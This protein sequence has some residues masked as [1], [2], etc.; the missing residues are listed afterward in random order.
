MMQKR[1]K[2]ILGL[3]FAFIMMIGMMN[4]L[5]VPQ[6]LAAQTNGTQLNANTNVPAF[7][8]KFSLNGS[9]I[10][11]LDGAA[12]K[13]V[14]I[15]AVQ[16]GGDKDFM[17]ISI[18]HNKDGSIASVVSS[19]TT[20][21]LQ[22]VTATMGIPQ[23]TEGMYMKA[24][25]ADQSTFSLLTEPAV[26]GS[27]PTVSTLNARS[28]S[29]TLRSAAAPI[30]DFEISLTVNG[31]K[32][33]KLKGT[34]G[35]TIL[36]VAANNGVPKDFVFI[37]S[38]YDSRGRMILTSTANSSATVQTVQNSMTI[39]SNAVNVT[40]KTMIWD[41]NYVPLAPGVAIS[42]D[43]PE[44]ELLTG[45]VSPIVYDD[46]GK[47]KTFLKGYDTIVELRKTGELET[48]FMQTIAAPDTTTGVGT[49]SFENV[50]A[51]EYGLFLSRPGYLLR[52]MDVTVVKSAT[53]T[54][55]PPNNEE[56]FSLIPGDIN[57]NGVVDDADSQIYMHSMEYENKSGS[58]LFKTDFNGDGTLDESELDT[59]I[60]NMGAEFTSYPG[61]LNYT[62][63]AFLQNEPE[64]FSLAKQGAETVT[65][66][67][68]P[69]AYNDIGNGPVF[70]SDYDTLVELRRTDDMGHVY[71]Q[72]IA[73]PDAT[74]G[75]GTFTF[76]DVPTGDYALLLYRPGHMMRT[77]E[78]HIFEDTMYI[79]PSANEEIFTLWP[80]DIDSNG[81]VENFDSNALFNYI[82]A[83]KELMAQWGFDI[84]TFDYNAN[85]VV[86]Q[87]DYDV[88]I[89]HYNTSFANYPDAII[90][91]SI[92][93]VFDYDSGIFIL[94]R[95][96]Q[97]PQNILEI[98]RNSDT[99]SIAW[100]TVPGATGYDVVYNNTV[101]VSTDTNSVTISNVSLETSRQIYVRAKDKT[102]VSDW[103]KMTIED[104][105]IVAPQVTGKVSP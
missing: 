50:P 40:L 43:P 58:A 28:N 99:I 93:E 70:L 16:S 90:D 98:A 69:V 22:S 62:D 59:L 17:L 85:G 61:A 65:G 101:L 29:M 57:A 27:P 5:Y 67:V 104:D 36:G 14:N 44:A 100:D 81:T 21:N 48:T 37:L 47:G 39:P 26:I 12:G 86:D 49:F 97:T 52:T 83:D 41:V 51:G 33:T 7:Q 68:A 75:V 4:G 105:F 32:L 24:A 63:L 53:T 79:K 80:G 31:S 76:N 19:Y 2:R 11:N 60:D 72:T 25:V 95:L 23:N 42:Y 66:K 38:L 8:I 30:Q 73:K 82:G 74:P 96:L 1:A 77:Q 89:A 9:E 15:S 18:L 94:K 92:E 20:D 13:T 6:A 10:T 88:S 91:D 64:K 55:K 54:L 103:G 84:A 87:S 35:Q 102:T 46:L 78:V 56:I 3:L 45:K 34:E 71:M